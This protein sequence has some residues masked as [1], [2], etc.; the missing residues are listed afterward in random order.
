MKEIMLSNALCPE[1]MDY[2][3]AQPD[4]RVVCRETADVAQVWEDFRQADAYLLR[5]GRLDRQTIEGAP[6]LRVIARPGVGVDT[7]D[8][9]AATEQGIPV[10]V[11][12]GANA[13]SVAEHTLAMLFALSKNLIESDREARKGNYGIRGKGV[14]VELEGKLLGIAGFGRI[15]RE[16]AKMAQGMGLR[17]MVYDPFATVPE[18]AGYQTADSLETLFSAGDFISLHMPSTAES[19]GIVDKRLLS[20]MKETA[21]LVNCARGDLV[22]EADLYE[23][24]AGGRLAGA[25]EDMMAAEP[26]DTDSPLLQLDN[27][28]ISPHMAALSKESSLRAAKMA[29]DG[30]LAVLNGE[31]YPYVANPEVYEHEKWKG[32]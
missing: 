31:R 16:V 1:G 2:L 26:F 18:G 24:L 7:I 10:V 27:F 32:R 17:V 15:G 30:I 5:M 9:Q 6:G 29:V 3:L 13:R 23:A 14:S 11:T 28:I 8:V 22:N 12:P 20:L 19:R 21:F 4:V 25:A